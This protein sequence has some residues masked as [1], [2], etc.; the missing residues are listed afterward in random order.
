[1]SFPPSPFAYQLAVLRAQGHEDRAAK[2]LA[3]LN[4]IQCAFGGSPFAMPAPAG[5]SNGLVSC[6]AQIIPTIV[7]RNPDGGYHLEEAA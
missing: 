6:P 3:S 4:R 7:R 2:L 5:P 1:V